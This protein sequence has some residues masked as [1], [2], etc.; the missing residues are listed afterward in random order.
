MSISPSSN[1]NLNYNIIKKDLLGVISARNKALLLQALTWVS[2]SLLFIFKRK[3]KLELEASPLWRF[4]AI[5]LLTIKIFLGK[6]KLFPCH[7]S[8]MK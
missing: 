2:S 1:S 8:E 5:N 3:R 7:Y 6:I 4:F